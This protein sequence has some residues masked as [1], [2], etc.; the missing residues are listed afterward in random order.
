MTE[1]NFI[2]NSKKGKTLMTEPYFIVKSRSVKVCN[3]WTL[4]YCEQ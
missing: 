4:L 2:V 3:D 1:P